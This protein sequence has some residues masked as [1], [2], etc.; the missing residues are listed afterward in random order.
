MFEAAK[1]LHKNTFSDIVTRKL[2]LFE[3][4][5]EEKS[6]CGPI[7]KA[8]LYERELL[9]KIV[10]KDSFPPT[11]HHFNLYLFILYTI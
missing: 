10:F 3:L 8:S 6:F 2:F 9:Q 7:K 11:T 1:F 5:Y 4:F